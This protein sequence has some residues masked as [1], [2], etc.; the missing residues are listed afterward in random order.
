VAKVG[1]DPTHAYHLEAWGALRQ[2]KDA[3]GLTN[4]ADTGSVYTGGGGLASYIKVVPGTFDIQSGVSYGSIGSMV[5][6]IPDVTYN[7]NGKP[8]PIMDRAAYM[9]AIGHVNSN[10]DVILQGGIERGSKAGVSGDSTATAYGY[11]NPWGSGSGT[12]NAACMTLGALSGTGTCTQDNHTIRSISANAVWK[13]YNGAA[14]MVVF[15]PTLLYVDR[16][17]FGDQNGY[18]PKAHNV[19]IDLALRYYPF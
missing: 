4:L 8:V 17:L 5:G 15:M 9:M 16:T 2:Y 12:G 18:A 10:L 11:G 1:Y 19:S 14:G 3:P 6:N 7:S 13:V